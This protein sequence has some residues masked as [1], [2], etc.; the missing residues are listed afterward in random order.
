MVVFDTERPI[1]CEAILPADTHRGAPAGRACRGQFHAGNGIEDAEAGVRHRRAALQVEQRCVPGVADLAGEQ[2][3]ATGFGAGG[4]R[5]IQQAEPLVGEISP[6]PLS[7]KAKNELIGL[8]AITE[9]TADKAAGA[10]PAALSEAHARRV[11]EIH[12]VVAL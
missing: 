1:G 4:E 9:L 12:T 3:D 11:K 10:I 5:R 7:S 2:A 6:T 8:P